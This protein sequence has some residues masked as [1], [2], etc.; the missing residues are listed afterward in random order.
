[1]AH[2]IL[3]YGSGAY[4]IEN[5]RLWRINRGVLNKGWGRRLPGYYRGAVLLLVAVGA[6]AGI[7]KLIDIFLFLKVI[8]NLLAYLGPFIKICFI[9]TVDPV[10]N[11]VGKLLGDL[12][13]KGFDLLFGGFAAFYC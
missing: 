4:G 6:R 1:M 9:G 13:S 5:H 10:G 8:I 3:A 11:L 12:Y 7:T 2:T